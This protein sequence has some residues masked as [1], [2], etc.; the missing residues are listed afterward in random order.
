MEHTITA[1][2]AGEITS[3][4]YGVGDLVDEGEELLVIDPADTESEA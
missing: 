3:L 1:P 2:Y 4:R